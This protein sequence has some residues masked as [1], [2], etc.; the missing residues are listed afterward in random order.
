MITLFESF[1]NEPK[2]GDYVY[3]DF[4]NVHRWSSEFLGDLKQ[5]NNIGKIIEITT[6]MSDNYKIQIKEFKLEKYHR[7]NKYLNIEINIEDIKYFGT[8]DEIQLKIQAEKYNL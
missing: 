3:F 7:L 4:K 1:S 2:V 6:R 5:T 8:K